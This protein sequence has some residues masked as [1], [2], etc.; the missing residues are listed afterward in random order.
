M[1]S[2]PPPPPPAPP[3]GF[4]P[5]PPPGYSPYTAA[6]A[7]GNYA[8]FG[9]RL[10]G[11]LLDGLLYGLLGAVFSVPAIILIV[12]SLKDCTRLTDSNGTR[13]ITCDSGQLKG[14]LLLA[15]IAIGAVGIILIAIL[16]I[17]AL[18]R[19]GQTWGRKIVGVKVVGKDTG[20]PLGFGKA[21]GRT[22]LESTI[23]G[24][25]CFLGFLWMLWDKDKQTWHDKIVNSVVVK[26]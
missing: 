26:V 18:G 12:S 6:P 1:S 11:R 20:A 3:G 14:G 24:W 17:R 16:Y 9:A 13:S 15:G 8:S 23:S 2:M 25:L 5:A 4:P 19:T 10:G 22:L 7:I 21:L